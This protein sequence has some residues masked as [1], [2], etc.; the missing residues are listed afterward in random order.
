MK[1]ALLATMFVLASAALAYG[2]D[3][4]ESKTSNRVV[5]D[6]VDLQPS[7]L[8]GYN[9]RVYLSALS[10]NGQQLDLSESKSIKLFVGASEKKIPYALGSYDATQSDTAMVVLVQAGLD[11]TEALPHIQESLDH[12]LLAALPD[13]TQVAVL[14]FGDTTASGKLVAIKNVRGKLTLSGDNFPGDPALSDSLDRALLL[15]RKAKTEPEGKPIRKI[16]VVIGDGRDM[17]ADKD[18]VTRAGTKAAKDGVRIHTIAYSANDIRRP[19]LALGE[20]SKRSL[21]TFRWVR[22]SGIDSWKAAFEQL[23]DEINKQYVVTY[24]VDAGEEIAGRKMHITTVRTNAESN[25]VKIPEPAC[26]A[27]PCASGYCVVDKCVAY[28]SGNGRGIFGWI[29]L[30]GGIAVGGLAVLLVIG[31]VITKVQESKGKAPKAPKPA[32]GQPAAPPPGFLPNGRPMPA[33]MIM[34]G[35]RTGERHVLFNGFLIGKQPGCTLIIEDGYTSSQH[36]QIGMDAMG[37]CKI[38]D[39]GS[40]NGTFVNGMRITES[41]LTHGITLRIGSTEIRFLAE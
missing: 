40:T 16:I 26:G 35:P 41:A 23:R 13:R 11:Y 17:A 12:D 21:G 20:L 30:V 33:L 15:L 38:Y 1:R 32:P 28:K 14:T 36:A 29:L 5:V 18:R 37:N 10:L 39:R 7:P 6:R 3:A 4:D 19:M 8:T 34:S 31:F 2:Q 22:K 27:N 24:F 25:E 9:L